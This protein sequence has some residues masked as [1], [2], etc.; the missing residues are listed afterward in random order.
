MNYERSLKPNRVHILRD[1]T[2][3]KIKIMLTIFLDRTK[4]ASGH[5][6]PV[7]PVT[8]LKPVHSL[9]ILKPKA[10]GLH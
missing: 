5:D 10:N 6:K 4:P 1:I 3:F 9:T 2:H 7:H 8:V